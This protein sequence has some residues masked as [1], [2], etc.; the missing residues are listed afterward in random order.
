MVTLTLFWVISILFKVLHAFKNIDSFYNS[1]FSDLGYLFK[2]RNLITNLNTINVYIELH[3]IFTSNHPNCTI[4][5]KIIFPLL[6]DHIFIP[7]LTTYSANCYLNFC[8]KAKCLS[9]F[10]FAYSILSCCAQWDQPVVIFTV[11]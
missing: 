6:L 3:S 9:K 7:S 1:S 11:S 10:N 2:L 4:S 8:S 5:L